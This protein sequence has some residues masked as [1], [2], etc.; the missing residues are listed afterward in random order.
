M[1]VPVTQEQD[2]S[3][4]G[5]I[6]STIGGII[7]LM[8]GGPTGAAIGS[9]MGSLAGGGSFQDAFRTGIMNLGIGALPGGQAYLA[10][11]AIGQ[12]FGA[13]GDGGGG[14]GNQMAQILGSLAGGGGGGQGDQMAQILGSLAGGGG[15]G[16]LSTAAQA[17][18]QSSPEGQ[19]TQAQA[20]GLGPFLTDMAKNPF[21]MAT[22]FEALQPKGSMMSP[23]QQQQMATGERLP[24]YRGT[25]A[26]DFRYGGA[27]PSMQG[28]AM[29]GF[30]EG[31]TQPIITTATEAGPNFAG[32]S[33]TPFAEGGMVQS[34]FGSSLT[35]H[36]RNQMGTL[37]AMGQAFQ[38]QGRQNMAQPDVLQAYQ[39]YL[40]QTYVQPTAEQ[41]QGK[42]QEFVGL[43]D[44]A[45]GVHFDADQTFGFGGGPMQQTMAPQM[46]L[47]APAISNGA[48]QQ[49][50]NQRMRGQ[51]I[52]RARQPL[53]TMS[54]QDQLNYYS[55]SP[56]W[57]KVG[58]GAFQNNSFG[59][60]FNIKGFAEGG[61]IEG[62]GT[63]TSD[64]IPAT[65]YQNGGPVQ[66]AML[67]D[68][69]FVMTADAV[70]G[71]GGG[72]RGA[73]AAK[74]YEMMNRLERRA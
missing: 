6:L 49:Y 52:P 35:N 20:G 17:Q 5:G 9:G 30:I 8:V 53:E 31:G 34:P 7:G 48:S 19:P 25:A 26:P 11:N 4:N 40:T 61:F 12:I 62:P 55:N 47:G 51:T 70:R 33:I 3:N 22:L 67:S 46:G 42:V 58:E 24:D 39:D 37:D 64:S 36:L 29:G 2:T 72:N 41:M 23:L 74:M 21:V 15:A 50:Q 57:T 28:Y 59:D 27:N 14:Q 71:A 45:E 65:I 68:G 60:I 43:V 13:G 10:Q 44:Q 1:N 63:G 73:G 32:M 54:Q 66:K 38:A 69:E 18:A 56:E 16:G